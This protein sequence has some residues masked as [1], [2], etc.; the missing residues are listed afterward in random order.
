MPNGNTGFQ[1]NS[2]SF[3][4]HHV[5]L[6]KKAI[7]KNSPELVRLAVVWGIHRH[8]QPARLLRTSNLGVSSS[9]NDSVLRTQGSPLFFCLLPLS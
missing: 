5:P 9:E 8:T 3:L 6:G 7:L 2:H 4:L 1:R